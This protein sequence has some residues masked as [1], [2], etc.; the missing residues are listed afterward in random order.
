M[1]KKL[2]SYFSLLER[3]LWCASVAVIVL[4][5]AIF[6]GEDYLILS[7]S[8]I[9]VT[10]LIFSAKGNPVGQGLM[11]AFSL[12]YGVISYKF[13]Y[14]GEMITYVGMTMPMAVVAL[15]AWLK[16]PF[17]GKRSQVAVN[18]PAKREY[19]LILALTVIV[20]VIFYFILAAFDTKNTIPS[21]LSVS[22]SFMA[23]YLTFRRDPLFALAYA[24]NDVILIILWT[25][26]SI[27]NTAY[28]PVTVCFAAFL[29]NDI[30]GYISWRKMAR[31]QSSALDDSPQSVDAD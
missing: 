15:V 26:A 3:I 28:I 20:T 22:T 25:M 12:L 9:G 8:I 10:S 2:V 7:A 4:S 5:F 24:A 29:A 14:Y 27:E 31:L 6:D 21:T 17:H 16:N 13:R 23:V 18:R 11:V 19:M 30:Y 1:I